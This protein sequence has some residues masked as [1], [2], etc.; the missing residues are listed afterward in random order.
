MENEVQEG[1]GEGAAS[2]EA[3]AGLSAG[4]NKVRGADAPPAGNTDQAGA[5][6]GGAAAS[7]A[8]APAAAPAAA[9]GAPAAP[10]KEEP[11]PGPVVAAGLTDVELRALLARV[12]DLERASQQNADTTRK[13]FGKFG[14]LQQS[15]LAL[16]PKAADSQPARQIKADALK[17][18]TAE[19]GPEIAEAL[20][21]DLSEILGVAPPAGADPAKFDQM[22]KE[23]VSAAV[24]KTEQAFETRLLTMAHPDW[25]AIPGT[26]DFKLWLQGKPADYRAQFE[27]TWDSGFLS[28]A[29]S[30]FKAHKAAIATR[31]QKNTVRLGR[32]VAPQGSG[33]ARPSVLPDNAGLQA[34]FNK[35]R[36][37]GH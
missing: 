19:F 6:D 22:V 29:F 14:E 17:R 12:P 8:P 25:K 23:Q 18:L 26:P 3:S 37:P 7:P 34:G 31:Q 9:A 36:K 27:E 4:F 20:S 13:I 10:P 33:A 11:A 32:A 2:S 24:T 21:S 28:G 16:Q 30:E 15:I 1:A 35:V 5:G